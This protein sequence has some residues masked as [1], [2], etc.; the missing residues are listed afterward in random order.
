MA[1]QLV[2]TIAMR[3]SDWR[4][5]QPAG[6][7]LPYLAQIDD[8][9]LLLRDGRLMQV[10]ALDGLLFETADTADINYR[11]T[12]RDAVY[13]SIGS[14]R[15]AVYHHIIRR[16]V[17]PELDAEFPDPFSAEVNEK[18]TR[19]LR[20]RRLFTNELYLCLIRRPLQGRGGFADRVARLV[21]RSTNEGRIADIANERRELDVARDGL[22]ATLSEYGAR[23]LGTYDSK[24]GPCSEVLEYLSMIYNEEARSVLLPEAD[25]GQYL[26][27]R[28]VS[29]GHHT[30]E[31]AAAGERGRSF[32]GLVS[33]K[34][35]PGLS[36]PGMLDDLMRLPVELV[37]TQSF[38][39]VDRQAALGRVNLTLRRMRAA[40]DEALSLRG[41]L[42][43][44]RDDLAAGRA[45]FGEHHLTVAVRGASPGDVNEGVA[46]VQAALTE[47]GVISVREEVA[48]EPT[49]WAQFPGNFAYV[50]R[51]SLVSS[52]NFASLASMHNF[53]IGQPEGNHW[54]QAVTVLETTAA[55]PYHFNFHNGDL[56]NFTVIGPSG[57]GKT[58]VLNFLLVQARKFRPRIVFFDKDRGA[59]LFLRAI[60]GRYDSLRVGEPAGLNPLLL[61]DTAAN[62]RFLMDWLGCLL[63]EPGRAL[64]AD[65][66]ARI[67]DAVDANM[68]APASYRRLGHFAQLLRGGAR[69]EAGDLASRLAPWWGA[70]ERAWLFDNA[71]DKVDLTEA[72][73]GF[74]MTRILDH[75]ATRTPAM[76][77][78]FHRVEQRLD[79]T[80]TIIVV[81]EGW[82]ALDDE[83]FTSRI[84]DWEKTIRKRNGIVGFVTQNAEDAL[85]S[86]IASA[87]VE[88]SATQIFMANSKALARDYMS[89]FGLTQ[90][91]YDLVRALPDNAHAFL[92][93]HGRESVVA[94]LDLSGEKD[95]LTILSG[96]E[97]TVRMLDEIR[98]ETGDAPHSWMPRLLESMA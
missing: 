67:K 39:F 63:A 84:R 30:V 47:L 56:G 58:V 87:I 78:L 24:A 44:A 77:Y 64:S 23:L 35:Y 54:G 49:F 93:K 14:S 20:S 34:E 17:E 89:G 4:Q 33:I 62:R 31:L 10:I 65:E 2:P 11:K 95:L 59:E 94:R 57:S 38:A 43:M 7:H 66:S 60:G 50:P 92:I 90:H 8:H 69:P 79:G 85:S 3:G 6:V 72:V 12:L 26:P 46:E 61:D 75:P 55:G 82:K 16:R 74:D 53:P 81:D 68:D 15:F 96:R 83:V 88:Q 37:V 13:Q 70:G 86:R 18:W 40:D 29:F 21:G 91:E 51:K 36:A 76:M 19:R 45:A 27:Y 1:L 5:E 52:R 9:T 48:L 42:A 97:H 41:E 22:L 25:I 28:R 32:L 80:P 98:A 73:I 71:E